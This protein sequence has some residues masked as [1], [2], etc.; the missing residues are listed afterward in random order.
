MKVKKYDV[1]IS[2]KR[3]DYKLASGVYDFLT[4]KGLTVFL[5]CEELGNIHESQYAAAIDEALDNSI[6]M[7]V[8]ASSLDY[9]EHK[10]VKYEWFL[11]SNDLKAGYR[12]GNLL[13]ILD[14]SI[15]LRDLPASLRHQQSFLFDNYKQ[16]ILDYLPVKSKN[17]Q[18]EAES[19]SKEIPATYFLDIL[20]KASNE[21][22]G[23]QVFVTDSTKVQFEKIAQFNLRARDIFESVKH[24]I[25]KEERDHLDKQYKL[26]KDKMNSVQ[27]KLIKN[28]SKQLSHA[29][30]EIA[31]E[32]AI[33]ETQLRFELSKVLDREISKITG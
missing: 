32:V 14:K 11:F 15:Q 33:M 23:M 4:S 22:R 12:D 29:D 13:T 5:A 2:S 20:M 8:V 28:P 27:M 24:F 26:A 1:F 25:S 10:W 16:G 3:E 7:I 9:I 6:H 17:V 21:L 30:M 31:R 19:K 18:V